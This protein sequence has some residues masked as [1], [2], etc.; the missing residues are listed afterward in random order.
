MSRSPQSLGNRVH[1]LAPGALFPSAVAMVAVKAA[2][3]KQVSAQP[4]SAGSNPFSTV[5]VSPFLWC[6]PRRRVTRVVVHPE[7]FP[8]SLPTKS[9]FNDTCAGF[10]SSWLRGFGDGPGPADSTTEGHAARESGGQRAW[11][12]TSVCHARTV[13]PPRSTTGPQLARAEPF[14]ATLR[15]SFQSGVDCTD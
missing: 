7:F 8:S 5:N 10:R 11:R 12:R 14:S 13:S 9:A 1:F 15:C 3:G 6:V 2:A 4:G